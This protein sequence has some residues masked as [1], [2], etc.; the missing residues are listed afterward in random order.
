MC[1]FAHTKKEAAAGTTNTN[2]HTRV[3]KFFLH[4]PETILDH[5]EEEIY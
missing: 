5:S 3:T 1:M 4:K 2:F